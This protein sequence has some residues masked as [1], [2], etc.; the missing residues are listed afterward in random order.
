MRFLGITAASVL[1]CASLQAQVVISV[2]TG[3]NTGD[4]G[5]T[6]QSFTPSIN[7]SGSFT[8]S[9]AFLTQFTFV[10]SPNA[11]IST[12]PA[13]LLIF[14]NFSGGTATGLLQASI[15]S[16]TWSAIGANNTATFNFAGDVAL[17]INTTYFAIFSDSQTA[18]VHN[19]ARIGRGILFDGD[20]YSGGALFHDG[21][22]QPGLDARF[23]AT[24]STSPVPEPSTWAMFAGGLATLGLVGWRRRAARR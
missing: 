13:F 4:D 16:Q 22:I 9:S 6:G 19:G 14:S 21:S 18:F 8:G 3:A 20:V 5:N 24:F 17:D 7:T 23:T 2:P 12:P 11:S 1:F 15:N 10:V